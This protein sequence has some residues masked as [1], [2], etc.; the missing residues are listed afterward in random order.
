MTAAGPRVALV[1]AP[2]P[3]RPRPSPDIQSLDPAAV[4]GP[5]PAIADSLTAIANH[6]RDQL[7]CRRRDA[8][9]GQRLVRREGALDKVKALTF[10]QVRDTCP[11]DSRR[12]RRPTESR[13]HQL[14]SPSTSGIGRGR[15]GHASVF[16]PES[17]VPP[18]LRARCGSQRLR[19]VACVVFMSRRFQARIGPRNTC[20]VSDFRADLAVSAA[21]ASDIHGNTVRA[22][23]FLR[24]GK[25]TQ[26]IGARR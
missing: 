13:R 21:G 12:M 5:R 8:L 15:L 16:Q 26:A 14:P 19:P 3:P 20:P 17:R 24:S 9:C 23:N 11:R 10:Q 18:R 22:S 2:P 1:R 7:P 25:V 6:R 4:T